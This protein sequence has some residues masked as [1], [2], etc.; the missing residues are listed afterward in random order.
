[1]G[2]IVKTDWRVA[3][4]YEDPHVELCDFRE[5]RQV[6]KELD[7]RV[8]H[9]Q[10]IDPGYDRFLLWAAGKGSASLEE[11]AHSLLLEIPAP[12]LGGRAALRDAI[13]SNGNF[14]LLDIAQRWQMTEFAPVVRSVLAS[15]ALQGTIFLEV[16]KPG[17]LKTAERQTGARHGA[18][19]SV[20]PFT[21]EDYGRL[22]LS[23]CGDTNIIQAI[24]SE[25]ANAPDITDYYRVSPQYDQWHGYFLQS[26]AG[27][28]PA[29]EPAQPDS[30]I[31]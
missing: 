16:G 14:R 18:F 13:A 8:K 25:Y 30:L 7:D 28:P 31:E 11:E 24:R 1:M 15:N 26:L 29:K 5:L 20:E 9:K 6:L 21:M 27:Y 17:P 10:A 19:G 23:R 4:I 2:D 12:T 22:Y 3:R